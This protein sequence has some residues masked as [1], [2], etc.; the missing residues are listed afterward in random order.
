MDE[1]SRVF[2]HWLAGLVYAC[3]VGDQSRV[4]LVKVGQP[5]VFT[6]GLQGWLIQCCQHV[7]LTWSSVVPGQG[8]REQSQGS[9][10]FVRDSDKYMGTSVFRGF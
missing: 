10:C 9:A 6:S 2:S 1:S 5:G 4:E 8:P 3:W 7:I